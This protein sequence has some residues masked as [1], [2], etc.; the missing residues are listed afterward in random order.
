MAIRIFLDTEF[1][2]FK[3]SRIISIG[4]VTEDGKRTFYAEITNTYTLGHCSGFVKADVLPQLDANKIETPVDYRKVYAKMTFE[5][6]KSHLKV[7]FENINC[8]QLLVYSDSPYYDWPFLC[9]L[10]GYDWPIYLHK[11]C[12]YIDFDTTSKSVKF[13]NLL[14]DK[15]QQGIYREHHALDDAIVTS[16]AW[17]EMRDV[18]V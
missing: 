14:F 18:Q 10:L 15:F 2:C 11:K 7:W 12:K 13:D 16:Q 3:K 17:A 4:L 8:K 6:C 1:T 9:R 5:E